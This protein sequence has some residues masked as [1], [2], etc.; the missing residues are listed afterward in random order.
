MRGYLV[1][2][3]KNF[4]E[5]KL[6]GEKDVLDAIAAVRELTSDNAVQQARLTEAEA[7]VKIWE[8][9]IAGRELALM[10]DP[11]TYQ[12]ARDLESSGAGKASMD[13]LRA[14]IAQMSAEEESLLVARKETAN[15]DRQLISIVTVVSGVLTLAISGIALMMIN[16]LLVKPLIA[17]TQAMQSISRGV[18]NI[19][20][21]GTERKDE[22]G[23]MSRAFEANADRIARLAVEQTEAEARQI[24][25]RRQGMLDLA[26]Q[27]ERNVGGIVELVSS[28]ATEM[29]A[30][31]SQLT[32]T[33]QEASVQAQTVSAAAEEASTNVSSVASAAEQLGASVSEI[34]RQVELSAS[35]SKAAVS[36]TQSTAM[37]VAELSE[38]ATRINDIVALISGIAG[39]TNLLALNATIESARAGEAGKGFAVVASEVKQLASQTGRA[40]DDITKQIVAIQSTTARAVKAIGDISTSISEIDETAT[41]ISAAVDQQ[42][43]ATREIVSSVHQASTGTSEVTSNITGVARAAEETGLGASQ[44]LSAS[45]E[46]TQQAAHLQ[47]ELQKFLATVRAA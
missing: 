35:K 22:L 12:E 8:N 40:T 17:L 7:L 25:E 36:E 6:K 43:S 32:A 14:K 47:T 28:A 11:A 9:D 20:V 37:I 10:S 3:D 13:A 5:P 39:Q 31:A 38:A 42:Y 2:A 18:A 45:G 46:L 26:D 19:K 24:R 23:D 16:G 33:A 29:Q 30:T 15:A 4:L 41:V 27:F 34:S 21:P 44:V 1:S